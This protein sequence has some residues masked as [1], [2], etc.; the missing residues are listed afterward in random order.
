MSPGRD[1]GSQPLWE[2]SAGGP[3]AGAWARPGLLLLELQKAQWFLVNCK[4]KPLHLKIRSDG[5]QW[6]CDH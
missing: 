1:T 5:P 4:P 3:G 2:P 6:E